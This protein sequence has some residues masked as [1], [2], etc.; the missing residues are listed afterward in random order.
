MTKG[1]AFDSTGT[2]R[3]ALWREWDASA[4]RL[5]FV[6]LNPS[7][8]DA[9]NDDPTLR[10]CMGFARAWGYGS[11]QIVNLFAYRAT[12]PDALRWVADAVGP[13]NDRHICETIRTLPNRY[14]R[15][16]QRR[17]ARWPRRSH[18][19]PAACPE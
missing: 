7:T 16:G 3:Y 1:A 15:M 4:P 13:E 18:S 10:R 9:E 8:A 2:Y 14:R 6:L 12:V 19:E 17:R 5:G 11:L